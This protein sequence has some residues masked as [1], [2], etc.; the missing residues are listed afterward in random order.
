[1]GKR[2]GGTARLGAYHKIWSALAALQPKAPWGG[3]PAWDYP[4]SAYPHR[5]H[6]EFSEDE[7]EVDDWHPFRERRYEEDSSVTALNSLA[8]ARAQ[9]RGKIFAR[10]SKA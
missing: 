10:G 1:M 2:P 9:R 4:E 5:R 3:A 8:T 7:V 6:E